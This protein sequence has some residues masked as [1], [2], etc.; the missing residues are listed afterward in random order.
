MCGGG[1]VLE[2]VEVA[3]NKTGCMTSYRSSLIFVHMFNF[4]THVNDPQL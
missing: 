2:P 1:R 4:L 3:E